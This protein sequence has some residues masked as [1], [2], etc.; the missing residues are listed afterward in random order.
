MEKIWLKHYDKWVSPNLEYPSGT[1]Y[2]I[3]SGVAERWKDR[4]CT[5]YL[6]GQLTYGELKDKVDA[7]AAALAARGIKKGDRI[8]ISLPSSPQFMVAYY[9]LMKL[10]AVVVM[11]NP[12]SS[13]R[14]I[15]FKF[16]DSGARGIVTLDMFF[17][18]FVA[19][20]R[21]VG[22]DTIIFCGVFDF[23]PTLQPASMSERGEGLLNMRSMIQDSLPQGA[24]AKV[25]QD[26]LAV[27]IYTG[28]TTGE[29]K[30]VMQTHRN[31]VTNSWNITNWGKFDQN[32]RGLC[33]LPLFHGFGMAVM[34]CLIIRGGSLVLIP[35][36]DIKNVFEQIHRHRPTIMIGVPTMYVAMNNYPDRKK[37]NITS[38]RVSM[39]GG[40]PLPISVKH[41]YERSTGGKLIEGFGLTESTCAVCANPIE[42][43][44]KEGS[45]GLPMSDTDMAIV[46]LETGDKFLPQGEIGEIVLKTQTVMKGYYRNQEATADTI[47]EGWLHT[48]DIGK[49]DEDGY[50]YILDRKKE[51]IIAGGFNIYPKEVEN[52]LLSHPGVMEAAVIGLPDSYRG[53][54]VK[55]FI[56]P[57]EGAVLTEEELADFCKKN[58][59]RYMVPKLFE[60]RSSLPKS[61]I[62]KIL[63]KDLKAEEME[64]IK[65]R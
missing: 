43:I 49:M 29:P 51:M 47:K 63:K 13:Q 23:H 22:M 40:A 31:H 16:K 19:S 7:F 5:I 37:Y 18:R 65:R 20:S 45:I 52:V 21:E 42:E 35:Q 36:F 17:D 10:G 15:F 60:F 54:T 48:G 25:K 44:N 39:S 8:I 34:N 1:L 64:K 41:E 30:G 50:F 4:T 24:Q 57:R 27:I 2:D 62:G 56:I 9:A 32:D 53:E 6:D 28:G 38:L 26:D 55:A 59:V 14:E 61:P 58:M 12:L 46:D 11:L 3:F 33:V